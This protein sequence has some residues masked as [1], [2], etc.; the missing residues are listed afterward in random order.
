MRRIDKEKAQCLILKR[1]KHLVRNDLRI[2]TAFLLVHSDRLDLH[3]NMAEGSTDIPVPS[4]FQPYYTASVGK[5]F[6]AVLTAILSEH[7]LLSYEDP[8]ANY[9]SD[10]LIAG[11][12]VYKGKDYSRDVRIKHLLNHTSGLPDYFGDKP[13]HGRQILK[14]LLEE[15]DHFWNP[16]EVVTWSKENLKPHFPPGAGFHYSD[17]GYQLLGLMI[18]K[19]TSRPFHEAL[20]LHIFRPLGMGHSYLLQHSLPD[21]KGEHPVASCYVGDVNVIGHRSLS[22]DYAGGG[23]VSTSEDLLAFMSALTHYRIIRKDTFGRMKNWARF[24][25][26]IDYGNG[27]MNIKTVPLVMPKKY[28]SWGNAGSVGSFMFYNPRLD[29]YFIGTLNRYGYYRKA[30]RLM[31]RCMNT[32]SRFDR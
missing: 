18:E 20:G 21:R 29:S 5:L 23:V 25:P 26:G 14:I 6:T 13:A 3:L 22:I 7:G 19:I 28:N 16:S 10:D 1:F 30:F 31:F 8:I 4:P 2:H 9:L 12:H 24:Y 17:T 32:L 15:P 27:L 11:L